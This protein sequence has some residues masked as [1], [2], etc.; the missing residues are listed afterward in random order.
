M[1]I[2]EGPTQHGGSQCP[3]EEAAP[4]LRLRGSGAGGQEEEASQAAWAAGAQAQAHVVAWTGEEAGSRGGQL[5]LCSRFPLRQVWA[6]VEVLG[7]RQ[8][9]RPLF[10]KQNR[11]GSKEVS[12]RLIKTEK[13]NISHELP[14]PDENEERWAL[15]QRDSTGDT[16]LLPRSVAGSRKKPQSITLSLPLSVQ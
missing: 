3:Q 7:V 4:A 9:F 14:S 5:I 2:Q 11:W 6:A 8:R 10:E 16:L 12:L 15:A 1:R 13:S